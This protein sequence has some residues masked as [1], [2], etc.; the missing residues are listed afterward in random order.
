MLENI[1]KPMI[2]PW[3]LLISTWLAGFVV[4]ACGELNSFQSLSNDETTEVRR[5][6]SKRAGEPVS[7]VSQSSNIAVEQAPI[8]PTSTG[9]QEAIV[10]NEAGV[11]PRLATDTSQEADD[12]D[13]AEAEANAD[14]DP[15]EGDNKDEIIKKI[16]NSGAGFQAKDIALLNSSVRSC[17]GDGML[18]VQPTM[19]LPATP[20]SGNGTPSVDGRIQ[21]LFATRYQPGDNI[22]D[23][24]KNNLVD[25]SG[26]SRTGIAA[27]TLSDTYLRSLETIGNVV[28]HNCDVNKPEC[29]CA[30]KDDAMKM[31]TRCLPGLD[32]AKIEMQKTAEAMAN[33][34]AT[35][36]SG[37]R[38]V[39]SS[40]ISSYAF[41]NAR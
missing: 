26:G 1:K 21:F 37:M 25:I 35:G 38:K 29:A 36:P 20:G 14:D 6:R 2:R 33:V 32:P 31:L 24:E 22:I 5:Q 15:M 16:E 17:L 27:D 13:V 28:A 34:C 30:T 4:M 8:V 19:L 11:D 9:D 12:K 40:F 41:A 10:E 23:V 3:I 39:I 18:T 7:P